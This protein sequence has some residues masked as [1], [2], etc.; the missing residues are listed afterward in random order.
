MYKTATEVCAGEVER[1]ES[2]KL[3]SE[4]ARLNGYGAQHGRSG[5]KRHFSGNPENMVDLRLP[6]IS[7]KISAEIRQCIARAD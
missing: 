7:D 6:F 2:R 1:E 3:A 5:S 4:I